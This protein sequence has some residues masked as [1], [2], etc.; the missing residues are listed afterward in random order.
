M[1]T[2]ILLK[3]KC[4]PSQTKPCFCHVFWVPCHLLF[5]ITYFYA[6]FGLLHK[7]K[8]AGWKRQEVHR[9]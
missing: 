6:H 4:Q 2:I 9:F 5:P 1:M 8:N 3:I 7:N